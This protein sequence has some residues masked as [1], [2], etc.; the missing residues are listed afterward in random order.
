MATKHNEEALLLGVRQAFKDNWASKIAQINA[1]KADSATLNDLHANAFYWNDFPGDAPAYDPTI[2]FQIEL[3]STAA[4]MESSST[5]IGMAIVLI[6]SDEL[7]ADSDI[8]MQREM[9]YRRAIKEI[10]TE[11]VPSQYRGKIKDFPGTPWKD[12]KQNYYSVF[13][14][15]EMYIAN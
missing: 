10:L 15:F 2:I 13:V 11:S 9:R 7:I 4:P 3:Q 5:H 12:K 6:F 8:T 14:G 1:E